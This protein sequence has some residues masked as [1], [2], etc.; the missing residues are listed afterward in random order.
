MRTRIGIAKESAVA[1]SQ[2]RILSKAYADLS[3][4]MKDAADK[5]HV[6]D[7]YNFWN[8]LESKRQASYPAIETAKKVISDR[9]HGQEVAR[10]FKDPGTLSEV[11]KSLSKYGLDREKLVRYVRN[12]TQIMKERGQFNN[13]ITQYLYRISPYSVATIPAYVIGRQLGGWVG[14]IG[15]A[16]AIGATAQ[17]LS[18]L[19]RAWRLSSDIT[20]HMLFNREW[21]DKMTSSRTRTVP[22]RPSS[23]GAPPAVSPTSPLVPGMPS[24]TSNVEL[25]MA[26]RA[27]EL[28][29][30]GTAA[31][32]PSLDDPLIKEALKPRSV[33]KAEEA[34]ATKPG[35]VTP[36][37]EEKP[38]VTAAIEVGRE[39]GARPGTTRESK[40]GRATKTRERVAAQREEAR[41]TQLKESQ[42]ALAR[43]NATDVSVE[44]LGIPEMEE[45]LKSLDPVTY[46]GMMKFRRA[47][48]IPEADWQ[49]WLKDRLLNALEKKAS[50]GTPSAQ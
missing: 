37:F 29:K 32:P 5:Y 18:N 11:S 20:E 39:P 31:A 38:K 9:L 1:P 35:L 27:E 26:G 7:E 42:D 21:P 4:S 44:H 14:G 50:E 2:V 41:R 17:Y 49:N 28:P 19:T 24:A 48:K 34:A 23:G 13:R 30:V 45:T 47:G 12:A 33:K 10:V 40:I 46:S 15:S 3:R 8:E 25:M 6:I 22:Y 36:S 16:A 43:A